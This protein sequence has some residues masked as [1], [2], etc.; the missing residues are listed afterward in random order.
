MT[1]SRSLRW[2]VME[3]L[4]HDILSCLLPFLS[5]G[6]HPPQHVISAASRHDRNPVCVNVIRLQQQSQKNQLKPRETFKKQFSSLSPHFSLHDEATG[7]VSFCEAKQQMRVLLD[8]LASENSGS[9]LMDVVEVEL[10]CKFTNVGRQVLVGDKV[11]VTRINW[12]NRSCVIK[13]VFQRKCEIVHPTVA[14]VDRIIVLFSFEEP[15]V[16]PLTLTRFLVEAES[17]GLP[18]TL[19][20]NKAELVQD[21]Y[22]RRVESSGG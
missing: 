6:S 12:K 7:T 10:N 15:R 22:S 1:K 9:M 8:T 11:L 20:L 5:A 14:N 13:D 16:Q 3:L 21:D 2:T 18:I 4:D 17:T 19:A